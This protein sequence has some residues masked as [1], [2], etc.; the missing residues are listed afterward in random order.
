MVELGKRWAVKLVSKSD[1]ERAAAAIEGV[2]ARTPLI[3]AH[4]LSERLGSEVRLKCENLQRAGAFKIRGA[5]NAISQLTDEQRKRG[6]ITYSSG[7]HGQA[8]ALA[9]RIYGIKAV[10]VMPTT[11]PG[12][13]VEGA[14][15]LG[16]EVVLEGTTSTERYNRAI[17]LAEQHGYVVIPPFDD[18]NV[19]AGQGT[20]AIEIL[21]DLPDVKHILV[22]VGGGGQLAGVSAYIK[23]TRPDCKVIGVEPET[24]DAMYQSRQAGEPVTIK[25][26]ASIADG[27]LPVRPGDMTYA[28]TAEFV[29]EIVRV[30]D[31][32]IIGATRDVIMNAKLLVEFSGAATVAALLS[33]AYQPPSGPVV[34]ILSGGNLD[35]AKLQELLK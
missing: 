6:V 3:E 27:L 15:K 7:N 21:E 31:D 32:A 5:Y 2:A 33:K 4:W 19:I 9:G 10:V 11:A 29:D 20:V 16:A 13:K 35:P 14:K 8:V 18:A 23:Q 1:I 24:A 22:P 25:K 34:A 30:S 28:H 17:Q 12:V 26:S